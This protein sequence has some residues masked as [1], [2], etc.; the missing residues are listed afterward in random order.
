MYAG[1]KLNFQKDINL[2][3]NIFILKYLLLFLPLDQQK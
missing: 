2:F 1:K 3:V